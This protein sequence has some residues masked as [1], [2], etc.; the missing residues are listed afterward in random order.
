MA[1][2]SA[3]RVQTPRTSATNAARTPPRRE[4]RG[5]P[6]A[7]KAGSPALPSERRLRTSTACRLG[8]T[9]RPAPMAVLGAGVPANSGA[10]V[11]TSL[12]MPMS[13]HRVTIREVPSQA[14]AASRTPLPT[15]FCPRPRVGGSVEKSEPALAGKLFR[16]RL[17]LDLGLDELGQQRQRLLPAQI[18]RL[19]GNHAGYALLDDGQ[20]RADRHLLQ[21]DGRLHLTG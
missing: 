7:R 11:V 1:S 3:R 13:R 5:L 16:R 10:A 9:I 21:H 8:R 18:A 15:G 14:R 6:T 4:C 12:R 17:L 20:L 2:T 19:H